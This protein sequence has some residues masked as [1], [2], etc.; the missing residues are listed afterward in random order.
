MRNLW[1]TSRTSETDVVIV[2][3]FNPL[4]S[5]RVV[6]NVWDI[7]ISVPPTINLIDWKERYR[8]QLPGYVKD[9]YRSLV[10]SR[11]LKNLDA[12]DTAQ[13]MLLFGDEIKA[14]YKKIG[15]FGND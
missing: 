12:F 8:G 1:R 11:G 9:Y 15:E 13:C 7:P 14:N 2:R 3:E 5:V 6:P 4:E 10:V